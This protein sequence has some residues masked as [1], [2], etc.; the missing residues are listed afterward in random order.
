MPNIL[1][2]AVVRRKRTLVALTA[3]LILS[4]CIVLPWAV[5]GT[6]F[7]ERATE[8]AAAAHETSGEDDLDGSAASKAKSS[9]KG[10]R[11]ARV[12]VAPFKAIGKLFGGG[13]KNSGDTAATAQV[14]NTGTATR[15]ERKGNR[16]HERKVT[17]G[18]RKSEEVSRVDRA[19]RTAAK[20]SRSLS[21]ADSA[22]TEY[23]PPAKWKHMIEGVPRDS[24]W[25]GR[26]LLERGYVNEA[27]AELSIAASVGS[28]LLEANNLLGLA[29]DRRGWHKQAIE[30]YERALVAVPNDSQTLA[31]LGYSLYLGG[32]NHAALKRL[33][34][35]AR[36]RPEDPRVLG[37]MGLVQARLGKFDDAYKSFARA[38]GEFEG[39]FKTAALLASAGRDKEAIKH[40]E[41][42]L[43][44]Q[45]NSS[46]V[47]RQLAELYQRTNRRNEAEAVRRTLSDKN[48]KPTGE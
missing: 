34:Q 22:P 24:L 10:N 44:L 5:R 32:N 29:Y 12:F 30:C 42:A 15:V 36:H 4:L 1:L 19:K 26:A 11:F 43:R 8:E 45:P 27:I 35:A 7:Y 39:R 48:G 40:Y 16:A 2:T 3:L 41:A 18:A 6:G 14:K 9:K 20:D 25:Q 31:N 38:G 17:G 33:Q 13:D 37:H 21:L 46:G 23:R 28:N 47:L